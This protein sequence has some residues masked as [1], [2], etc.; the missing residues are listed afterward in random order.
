[1]TVKKIVNIIS[2]LLHIGKTTARSLQMS[3]DRS[4]ARRI[5]KV[6][7]AGDTER[8]RRIVDRKGILIDG[9]DIIGVSNDK[10][11]LSVLIS[12]DMMVKYVQMR[13]T[14]ERYQKRG[15]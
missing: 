1:M 15:G 13:R 7:K 5:K 4:M 8:L 2:D 14:I 11:T 10:E 9:G 3:G 6:I 12:I